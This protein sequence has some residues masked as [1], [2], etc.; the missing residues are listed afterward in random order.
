MSSGRIQLEEKRA[1]LRRVLAYAPIAESQTLSR[2]LEFVAQRAVHGDI[3]HVKEYV[4]ATQVLNKPA[5][6]DP[7]LDPSVRVHAH[8]LRERLEE[9]YRG[10]GVKDPVRI[11][12][13]K[14]SY[15]PQFLPARRAGSLWAGVRRWWPAA[16]VVVAAAEAA[17]L[18]VVP[19]PQVRPRALPD[20]SLLVPLSASARRTVIAFSNDLFLKDKDG[21][22]FRLKSDEKLELA[23]R[24][25]SRPED[26]LLTPSLAGAGRLYLDADYSGTGEAV[27]I[28]LLTRYFSERGKPLE[29][30]ASSLFNPQELRDS[31]VIFLGSPRE[32]LILSKTVPPLDFRFVR[33]MNPAGRPFL[34]IENLR[35]QPGESSLYEARLNPASGNPQEVYAL[36]S[37][38]RGPTPGSHFMVLAGQSTA[39]TQAACEYVVATRPPGG[40]PAELRDPARLPPAHQILLKTQVHDFAPAHTRYV[41][42]HIIAEPDWAAIPAPQ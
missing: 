32:N 2:F 17:L 18:L 6:F 34:A 29:V 12:I 22:M 1:A 35:P 10:P 28:F 27:C 16:A 31:N 20:S 33:R 40:L 24:I 38:W 21:N 36:I 11:T 15:L 8:R 7:R 25:Q 3:Q 39:G 19:W 9:Y 26:L 13:P 4:I 5:D 30:R 41:T 42:R 14:G 23:G 37:S